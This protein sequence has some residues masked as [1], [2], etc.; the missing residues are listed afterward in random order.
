MQDWI[1]VFIEQ[2][3]YV[4]L[5]LLIVLENVFPP[6]PSEVILTFGGFMTT[7]TYL[8]PLGVILI[9]TI[10]ALIGAYLLFYL[11]RMVTPQRLE[12]LLDSKIAKRLH[13]KK[14]DIYKTQNWF[15]KHGNKAVF[16][17]RLVP[18]IRSLISIPAGMSQM[19][20]VSFS[21]YTLL[22]TLLWNTVLVCI[23]VYLGSQWILIVNLMKQYEMIWIIIA[24]V[25]VFLIIIKKKH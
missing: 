18:V 17:G 4:S 14:E 10:G 11:G 21:L 3:G 25:I 24:L 7:K 22:G 6:I 13:F 19:S 8:H 9:S 23:G 12:T 20:F 16:F 5:F 2:Y 1:M 15:L